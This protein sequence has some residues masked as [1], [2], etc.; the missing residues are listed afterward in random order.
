MN[1]SDYW[2]SEV[3][4][5]C[6]L[7]EDYVLKIIAL[8][9]GWH[10]SLAIITSAARF[11][12]LWPFGQLFEPF[13]DQFFDLAILKFGSFLGS[14]LGYFSNKFKKSCLNCF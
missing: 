5:V 7:L 12:D 11:G 6:P 2:G 1:V 9:R 4:L 14:F 3:Q 13:D 10:R 8:Y